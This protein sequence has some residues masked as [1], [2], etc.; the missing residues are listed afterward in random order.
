MAVPLP[1]PPLPSL[2][3]LLFP[4]SSPFSLSSLPL[5]PSSLPPSLPP[6][7]PPPPSLPPLPLRYHLTKVA[8]E[9]KES[10]MEELEEER[11]KLI[12]KVYYDMVEFL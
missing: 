7:P 12:A 6:S 1:P 4:L 3:F 2:F 5:L 9:R 8:L 11:E 10:V